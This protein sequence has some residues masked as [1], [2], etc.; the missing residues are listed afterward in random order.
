VRGLLKIVAVFLG[1]L[2][3]VVVVMLVGARFADGP[4]EIIAGGPFTTGNAATA[5]PDWTFAKDYQTVEFQLLDP[6]QSRTTFLVVHEGRVFIPSGYMTTWWGKIW[7]RWPL[8]AEKNGDAL[9]R[10]DGVLY[11]RR[12]VRIID[13]PAIV[14]VLAEIGR[15]YAPNGEPIPREAFDSGYM[16]L[17]ELLPR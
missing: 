12:L 8:H 2:A 5:E 1:G 15:K 13:D 16:W 3:F 4:L 6:A 9:L 14:P 10:I 7:K 11:Q 17:F